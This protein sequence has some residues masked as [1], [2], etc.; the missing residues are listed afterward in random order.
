MQKEPTVNIIRMSHVGGDLL[1]CS[2]RTQVVMTLSFAEVELVALSKLAVEVLGIRSMAIEW[3]LVEESRT[4]QLYA[5]TGCWK[6]AA[7]QCPNVVVAREADPESARV[8]K[9]SR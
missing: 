3:E 6:V 7:H 5:E 8:P 1:K 9:D 4:C 2:G